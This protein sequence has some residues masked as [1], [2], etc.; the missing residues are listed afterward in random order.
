MMCRLSSCVAP[1]LSNHLLAHFGSCNDCDIFTH[2]APCSF[3]NDPEVVSLVA[4]VLP[5]T[6]LCQMFTGVTAIGSGIVMA[7]GM[8]G[9]GALVSLR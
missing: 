6:A 7:R 9:V 1:R 5:I 4:S 2:S 8:Q 3:N